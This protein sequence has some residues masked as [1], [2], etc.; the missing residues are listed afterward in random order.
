VA[1]LLVVALVGA[2]RPASA[3]QWRDS[4][5]AALEVAYPLTKRALLSSDRLTKQGVVLVVMADLVTDLRYNV[6]AIRAGQV[7]E[8]SGTVTTVFTRD[9]IRFF[10][11]GERAFVTDIRV[12][13]DNVIFGLLSLEKLY[14]GSATIEFPKGFLETAGL[15]R[16]KGIIDQ[17]LLPEAEATAPKVI[18]LGQTREQVENVLGRPERIF[19]LGTRVIYLYKDIK[20]IFVDGR[21][22]DVQ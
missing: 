3:Q 11:A 1:A 14:R 5:R 21:V 2:A 15:D 7:G 16:V 13:E 22:S 18:A 10:A 4:L 17:V 8:P 20:V 6:T 19:D 9:G 12:E